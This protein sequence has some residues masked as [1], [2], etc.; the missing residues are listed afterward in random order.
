MNSILELIIKIIEDKKN[1]KAS[2]LYIYKELKKTGSDIEIKELRFYLKFLHKRT[3]NLA[4]N[5]KIYS[6]LKP[7]NKNSSMLIEEN[8][9]DKTNFKQ[10]NQNNTK[11]EITS[12]EN[13]EEEIPVFIY[14]NQNSDDSESEFPMFYIPDDEASEDTYDFLDIFDEENYEVMTEFMNIINSHDIDYE[15]YDLDDK[16]VKKLK[17]KREKKNRKES[18]SSDEII[19]FNNN[20]DYNKNNDLDVKNNDLDVK[21]EVNNNNLE[22]KKDNLDVKDEIE[23]KNI[24]LKK[25][26]NIEIEFNIK[27]ISINEKVDNDLNNSLSKL[28]LKVNFLLPSKILDWLKDKK[29][30]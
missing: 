3:K 30:N 21:E 5:K 26:D 11:V 10:S 2:F 4:K 16:P 9:F 15:I 24:E 12:S 14:G 22:V 23:V 29:K 6:I 27:N 25:D 28:N 7:F 13:S 8:F 19:E 20:K 18:N 1:K 17:D